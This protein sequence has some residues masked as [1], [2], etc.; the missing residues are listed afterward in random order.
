M[1]D[2]IGRLCEVSMMNTSQLWY[3]WQI[4]MCE[5]KFLFLLYGARALAWNFGNEAKILMSAA[6]RPC[7]VHVLLGH[8][9]SPSAAKIFS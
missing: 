4:G 9:P 6:R 7:F 8:T 5:C 3:Q 1:S 2:D